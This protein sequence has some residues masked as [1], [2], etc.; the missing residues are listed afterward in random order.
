M[1]GK[2][3]QWFDVRS[4]EEKRSGHQAIIEDFAE[5]IFLDKEPF[6]SGEEGRVA[7]EIV[8][9]IILSSFKGRVVSLPID[10]RAYD[11][12]LEKLRGE[13]QET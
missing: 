6:I 10:K 1:L 13:S 11:N 7:L 12:L 4:E 9:A 5:S 2:K 3:Y 8:N